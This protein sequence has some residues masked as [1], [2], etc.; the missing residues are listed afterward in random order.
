MGPARPYKRIHFT[1][2]PGKAPSGTWNQPS[3]VGKLF[4][5]GT[6]LKF[7]SNAHWM[8]PALLQAWLAFDYQ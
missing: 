3:W 6:S 2:N 8:T 7:A 4:T 5:E 1:S